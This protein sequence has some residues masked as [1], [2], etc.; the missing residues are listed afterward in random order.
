MTTV[1]LSTPI[2]DAWAAA[3]PLLARMHRLRRTDPMRVRLRHQVIC[4]C[5]PEARREA[6]R[7]RHTGEALEDLVQVATLGLILAVDRYDPQRGVAFKHFALPTITG[8]LKRHFR[9]RTWGVRVSRRVQELYQEVRRAE[10]LLAQQLGR[11]P[12][13]ADLAAS[14]KLSEED[15]RAAR[16]GEAAYSTRSLNYPVFGDEHTDE[17]GERMGRPDRAIEFVADHDALRRAWPLLP[18]RMRTILVLRFVDELSQSQ[19]ADK[20]EI[21]Q[22]HV[23]RLITRALGSLRRH[24]MA[25]SPSTG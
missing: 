20:L 22:M 4:E 5:A 18:Q 1:S 19:I 12:R 10:P 8:E 17:V 24:I 16:A 7:Y 11:I 23:S 21:S 25:D 14:L 3:D 6:G 2:T 13:T 15:I 9:D